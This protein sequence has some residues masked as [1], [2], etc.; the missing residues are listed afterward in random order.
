MTCRQPGTP[1]TSLDELHV[2]MI[3]ESYRVGTCKVVELT[4]W[5]HFEYVGVMCNNGERR[6]FRNAD[7]IRCDEDHEYHFFYAEPGATLE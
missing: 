6:I 3:V 2:G 4:T 5:V 1:I 7:P